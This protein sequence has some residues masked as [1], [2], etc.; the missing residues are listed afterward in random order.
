[1]HEHTRFGNRLAEGI[2][3]GCPVRTGSAVVPAEEKISTL[4]IYL[5][6]WFFNLADVRAKSS[7]N[8]SAAASPRRC[9]QP[10]QN[11]LKLKSLLNSSNQYHE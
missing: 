8:A 6:L 3:I 7:L 4:C 11:I 2:T 10:L 1:M 9:R 5:R